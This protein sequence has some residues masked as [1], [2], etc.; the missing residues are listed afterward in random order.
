VAKI[1][2]G[3][4][5]TPHFRDFLPPWVARQPWYRGSR[6]PSLALVG[7]YRLEDPDGEVGMEAHLLSDGDAVY[8]LPMTYRGAPLADAPDAAL[9]ATAEHS[10]L[11]ARWIYDA[12]ADPV[13]RQAI[14]RLARDGAT[15]EGHL[16]SVRGQ[17]LDAGALAADAVGAD[18]LVIDVRRV[19]VPGA[20]SADATAA[21]LVLGTWRPAAPGGHVPGGPGGPGPGGP[22]GPGPGGPGAE[23]SGCLAVI[24]S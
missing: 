21:G 12:P 3:A 1:N 17:S 4:T 5:I 6:V 15:V 16:A 9:I 10:E 20:P 23:V 19:L 11:G 7:A 18:G 13:W 22:G 24:R 14:V 8:Q 2:A